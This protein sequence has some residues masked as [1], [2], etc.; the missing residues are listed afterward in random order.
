MSSE[1]PAS[2]C[3]LYVSGAVP[4]IAANLAQFILS[5]QYSCQVELGRCNRD[6]Y[7]RDSVDEYADRV[8]ATKPSSLVGDDFVNQLYHDIETEAHIRKNLEII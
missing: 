4:T 5:P 6:W 1:I 8:L 7:T 3:Q 2:E